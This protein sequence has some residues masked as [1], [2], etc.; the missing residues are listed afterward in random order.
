MS[1]VNPN[2]NYYSTV[3]EWDLDIPEGIQ[4]ITISSSKVYIASSLYNS[5]TGKIEITFGNLSLLGFTSSSALY[6][7]T[8]DGSSIY[9]SSD[10]GLVVRSMFVDTAGDGT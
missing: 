1:L 8:F 10:T 9:E 3:F 6:T 5:S 7:G 2:I 4:S